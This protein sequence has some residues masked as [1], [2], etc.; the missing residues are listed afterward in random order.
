MTDMTVAEPLDFDFEKAR[1][2]PAP[3]ELQKFVHQLTD[4]TAY[5]GTDKRGRTRYRIAIE[6]PAIELDD[7]LR[8][9]G[10]P[11]IAMSRDISTSGICLVHTQRVTAAQLLIRLDNLNGMRVQVVVEISRRRKLKHFY[12]MSGNFVLRCNESSAVNSPQAISPAETAS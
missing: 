10:E 2:A 1:A 4:Q 7:E 12:E 5:S 8:P 6:V 3:V 9:M 11:F